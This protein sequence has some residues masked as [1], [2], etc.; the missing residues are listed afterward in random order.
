MGG[1][2]VELKK[3]GFMGSPPSH[4]ERG[5][6]CVLV[7]AQQSNSISSAGKSDK[8]KFKYIRAES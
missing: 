3:M 4:A 2:G 6:V 7:G 1:G 5:C 8:I